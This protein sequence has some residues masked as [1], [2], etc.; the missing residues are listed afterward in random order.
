[1][2]VITERDIIR[3]VRDAWNAQYANWSDD[4]TLVGGV[5]VGDLRKKL[6]ALDLETCTAADVNGVLNPSW[7]ET[8]CDECGE[9]VSPLVHIGEEPDYEVRYV[10]LCGDCLRKALKMLKGGA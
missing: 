10:R 2:K 1:M 3:N 9:S 4:R 5:R 7:V 8:I 6:A